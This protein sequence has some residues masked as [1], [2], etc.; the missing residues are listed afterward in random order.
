MGL[1]ALASLVNAH[2]WRLLHYTT[3]QRLTVHV[4]T[5]DTVLHHGTSHLDR[6]QVGTA[7]NVP[8][9]ASRLCWGLLLIRLGNRQLQLPSIFLFLRELF[10]CRTR[11][12]HVGTALFSERRQPGLIRCQVGAYIPSRRCC[13]PLLWGTLLSCSR[14]SCS[15][16]WWHGC[17]VRC[18]SSACCSS[19]PQE[20]GRLVAYVCWWRDAP[21]HAR[22]W[23]GNHLRPCPRSC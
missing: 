4:L 6:E 9:L 5:G 1:R 13:C 10:V 14:T 20:Q 16:R 11:L 17:L 12:R 15:E 18:Q 21:V 2:P 8:D 23:A 19:R 7:T 22:R 3:I